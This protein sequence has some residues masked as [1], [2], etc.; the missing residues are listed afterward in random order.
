MEGPY[1]LALAPD[2]VAHALDLGSEEGK[3]GHRQALL[4]LS[5]YVHEMF[6]CASPD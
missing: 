4:N 6:F 1:L 3:V 5:P 2:L